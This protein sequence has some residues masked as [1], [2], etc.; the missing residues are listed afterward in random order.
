MAE[1]PLKIVVTGPYWAG[2]STLVRSLCKDS[3]SIDADGTTIVMDYGKRRYQEMDI[4]L[5]G[6]PGQSRFRKMIE[7]VGKDADGILLVIDSA[8]P[9]TWPY[10]VT[11]I[12]EIIKAE[13]VPCVLC[14]N[15]QDL[16]K[17]WSPEVV[18]KNM[19]VLNPVIGTVALTGKNVE[20]ALG[21]LMK[22]ME[23]KGGQGKE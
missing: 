17:A 23:T 21:T 1:K 15:K 6:T 5:F 18:K 11:M 13:N 9:E 7:I 12:K 8:Y 2:K 4:A 10:S 16:P 19:G 22:I 14:A 20:L 3:F